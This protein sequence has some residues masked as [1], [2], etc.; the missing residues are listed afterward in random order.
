MFSFGQKKKS[1]RESFVCVSDK[2]AIQNIHDEFVKLCADAK[3]PV[4][5]GVEK[6]FKLRGERANDHAA[7]AK[8][9]FRKCGINDD[10]LG[11]LV[12][13]F[14]VEPRISKLE[15]QD[16]QITDKSAVLLFR[17]LKGQAKLIRNVPVDYRAVTLER[18]Q[19][20]VIKWMEN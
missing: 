8:L 10:V 17:L 11:M 13:A 4:P 7:K 6:E 19:S 9:N 16:N 20:L 5:K 3:I 15:I 12:E 1:R 18:F 2:S 14:S